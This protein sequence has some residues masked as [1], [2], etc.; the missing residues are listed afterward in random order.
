MRASAILIARNRPEGT[1]ASLREAIAATKN[2]YWSNQVEVQRR[3]VAAWIAKQSGN[4]EDAVS[5]C[6]PQPNLRRAWTNTP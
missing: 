6:V 3:E 5:G 1:L 2:T 4:H